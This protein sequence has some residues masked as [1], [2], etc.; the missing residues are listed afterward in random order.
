MVKARMKR[1]GAALVIASLP[2][3]TSCVREYKIPDSTV[4][5]DATSLADLVD[6]SGQGV[7][8]FAPVSAISCTD[9]AED[10]YGYIVAGGVEFADS[11]QDLWVMKLPADGAIVFNEES[12]GSTSSLGGIV[13]DLGLTRE[14]VAVTVKHLDSHLMVFPSDAAASATGAVPRQQAP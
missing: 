1:L 8:T 10:L 14:E 12:Q 11:N 13:T 9:D 7:L 6:V 5:L 2:V 4:V 3:L